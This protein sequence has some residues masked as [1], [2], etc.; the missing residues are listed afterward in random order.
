MGRK[1]GGH[2]CV[3]NVLGYFFEIPG[4]TWAYGTDAAFLQGR[5][6][7]EVAAY[8]KFYAFSGGY[9]PFI[10]VLAFYHFRNI[11]RVLEYPTCC[12]MPGDDKLKP[13]GFIA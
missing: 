6:Q 3:E 11:I 10:G 4:T 12:R 8:L 13:L 1:K 7:T 2:F 9:A 5:P